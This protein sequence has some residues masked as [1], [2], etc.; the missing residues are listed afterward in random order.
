MSR[1]GERST[2]LATMNVGSSPPSR[3]DDMEISIAMAMHP[4][5]TLDGANLLKGK[6]QWKMDDDRGNSPMTQETSIW[7]KQWNYIWRAI[8]MNELTRISRQTATDMSLLSLKDYSDT[9]WYEY[10][11]PLYPSFRI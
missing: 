6:P 4:N 8:W 3:D 9:M 1:A 10:R 11:R 7:F 2:H 5:S